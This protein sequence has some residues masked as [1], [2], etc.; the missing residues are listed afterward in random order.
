MKQIQGASERR[1]L[2]LYCRGL[3]TKP[4]VVLTKGEVERTE[5][6]QRAH[7]KSRCSAKGRTTDPKGRNADTQAA[8]QRLQGEGRLPTE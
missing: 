5:G 1:R 7:Y 2:L 6:I 3:R 8:G 4:P